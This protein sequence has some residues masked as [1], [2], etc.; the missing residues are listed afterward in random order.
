MNAS[1]PSLRIAVADDE[2]D[3]RQFFQ[4]LLTR[5]GHEVVGVAENGG[6]LV[7]QCR[8]AH[9]ELVITDVRM[10]DMDGTRAAEEINR[11]HP[12]PVILVTGYHELGR[13][14]RG[15]ADY[16]MG[17]LSKPI[18][19]MDLEA[20]IELAMLR[21]GQFQMLRQE[22]ASLRQALEDRKLIERVKGAVMKRLGVDE[23]EAFRRLRKLAS[24]HNRRLAEVA[25]QVANAEE[26][27]RQIEK[28]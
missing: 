18:K 25:Q 11:D 27:F 7:E 13:L 2:A 1:A 4:E 26:V 8:T 3:T 20:A 5:L 28:T 6:Q 12:V 16:I 19:S 23:E 21:F 9:P 15:A 17:Y 10:P 14:A 24:D 22:A